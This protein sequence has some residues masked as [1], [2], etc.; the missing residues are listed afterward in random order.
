MP[1]WMLPPSFVALLA[2]FRPV[3][4]RPSFDSF[5]VLVCGWVHAIGRHCVSD[6]I[7]AAGQGRRGEAAQQVFVLE[8]EPDGPAVL[9]EVGGQWRAYGNGGFFAGGNQITFHA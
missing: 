9:L 2:E 3:F 8:R 7:R 6:A 4:T 1:D 5:R